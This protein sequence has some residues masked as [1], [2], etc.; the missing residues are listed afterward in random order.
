MWHVAFDSDIKLFM[1]IKSIKLM[2]LKN[3]VTFGLL[4]FENLS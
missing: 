2:F 4:I 3:F 1:K